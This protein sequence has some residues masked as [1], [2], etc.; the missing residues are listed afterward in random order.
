MNKSHMVTW[1]PNV[2]V[3]ILVG[4]NYD[5]QKHFKTFL[6]GQLKVQVKFLGIILLFSVYPFAK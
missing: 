2:Y 1:P 3:Y 5:R 4:L 6:D